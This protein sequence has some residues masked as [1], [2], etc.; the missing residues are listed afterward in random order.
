LHPFFGNFNLSKD[1]AR[2]G[3]LLWLLVDCGG[4]R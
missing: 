2:Q 4:D 3:P 1:V